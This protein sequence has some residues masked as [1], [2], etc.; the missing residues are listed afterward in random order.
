MAQQQAEPQEVSDELILKE[1]E[2]L[3]QNNVIE[4]VLPTIPLGQ[5]WVVGIDGRIL[6]FG[7][8]EAIAFLAGTTAALKWTARR[9]GLSV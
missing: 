9:R 1:L 4:Y 6:K 3:A 7:K 8:D 5:E 2:G